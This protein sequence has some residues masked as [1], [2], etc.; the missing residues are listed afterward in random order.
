MLGF[1]F[2]KLGLG[3]FEVAALCSLILLLVRGLAKDF[4]DTLLVCKQVWKTFGKK[5]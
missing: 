3:V 1:D 4:M 2:E 5:Q